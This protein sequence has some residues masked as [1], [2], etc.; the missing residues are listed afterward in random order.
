MNTDPFTELPKLI[1]KLSKAISALRAADYNGMVQLYEIIQIITKLT[2]ADEDAALAAVH[3]L[4]I[5]SPLKQTI[6]SAVLMTL[7][8]DRLKQNQK[9]RLTWQRAA[10]TAN[11]SF[12]D[13]QVLLNSNNN[14]LSA[15]QRQRIREHPLESQKILENAGVGDEELI[16][17]VAQ[18]HERCDGS[19]YPHQLKGDEIHLGALAVAVCEFYTAMI[20]DRAY[21]NTYQAGEALQ[22]LYKNSADREKKLQ[23]QFIK[24]VGIYPPGTFVK[25]AS[26]EI[27]I[28]HRRNP[29]TVMPRVKAIFGP[30][31]QP[32]FGGLLR[33]CN[34]PK[35]KIT[36]ST[37]QNLRTSLDLTALWATD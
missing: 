15:E 14:P 20:D 26:G 28:V 7:L 29:D 2:D 16:N 37:N 23:T 11:I 10:L 9:D 36:G 32:Y 33:D 18:H 21:R 35:F 27:A 19:G 13:F 5:A 1:P 8:A 25:L 22:E 4:K 31:K 17:I 24:L 12:V 34:N 3:L 30:D 6:F